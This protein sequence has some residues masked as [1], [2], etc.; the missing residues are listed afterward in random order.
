M[1]SIKVI[2]ELLILHCI[3]DFWLQPDEIATTKSSSI[4]SLLTHTIVYSCCF[5][6]FGLEYM[7]ITCITHTCIDFV[8]S[9][10]CKYFYLNDQRHWFFVTIGVDQML[11]ISL[12]VLTYGWLH[13][14]L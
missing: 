9:R 1:I 2:I 7:I 10:I 8:T 6:M 13:S 12:L 5:F 4:L 11:H 3:G 14:G